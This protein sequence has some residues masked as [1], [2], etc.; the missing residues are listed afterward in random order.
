M[1]LRLANGI[2]PTDADE[3][4]AFV[5]A[6]SVLIYT[7]PGISHLVPAVMTSRA[8]VQRTALLLGLLLWSVAGAVTAQPTA[9]IDVQNV[10]LDRALERAAAAAEISLVYEADL[11]RN[12]HTSCSVHETSPEVLLRCL[13]DDQPVDFVQASSGTY[14]LRAAAGQPP[15]HG[16]L[17]GVVR[18][19]KHG[20]PLAK[21][22]V[23]LPESQA[24]VGVATDTTGRF[25]VSGLLPGPHTVVVSHLGYERYEAT[26]FVPSDST[27]RY[28]VGLSP[29]LLPTDSV[30]ID[31]TEHA[32][33]GSHESDLSAEE[34]QAV[35]VV[36]ASDVFEAASSLM[37]VTAPPPYADLH[38]QGGDT[39]GH[40]LRLDGV[41]VRDPVSTG[42]L[43][44]AFSPLALEGLTARKAGFG[45]LHGS[46]LSG[47]LE[48]EHALS[49]QD[50]QY[51]TVRI[52]PLSVNA[53]VQGTSSLGAT[54]MT[55]MAATRV[56]IWDVYQDAAL[57]DLIDRWSTLDP[58][59]AS[60]QMDTSLVGGALGAR[61]EPTARFYDVHGAAQFEFGPARRLHVSAYR[62]GSRIGADLV[63][64]SPVSTREVSSSLFA[65]SS[66]MEVP[67]YDQYAWTNT[68]AQARYETPV[69]ARTT[70]TLKASV[71]HYRGRSRSEMGPL[72][73]SDSM[74]GSLAAALARQ[75]AQQRGGTNEISE[76]NLSGRLDFALA[77][78]S[79][80]VLSAEATHLSSGFEMGNAFVPRLQHR[81]RAL[82]FTTSAEASLGVGPHTLFEGGLRLTALSSRKSL[83]AEPRGRIQYDRTFDRLGTVA[84]RLGGGLYR[85]YTSEFELSRDGATA[86]VP[87]TQVWLPIEGVLEPSRTYHLAATSSW[88]PTQ[89]WQITLEAYRKWQPHLLAVHYPAL[90][91]RAEGDGPADLS[92]FLTSSHGAAVGGGLRV[93]HE[94]AWLTTSLRY[95]YS[96][97]RR[98]FPGRFDGRL[99]P[100]PWSEPHRLALDTEVP[101]GGGVALELRGKGIWGRPWGYRR[102]YYA[103]LTEADLGTDWRTADLDRPGTHVLSPLYRFDA[104]LSIARSWGGVDVEG[105]IGVLNVL[106]RANAADWVLQPRPTGGTMRGVRTLP[107]RRFALTLQVG[108]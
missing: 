58:M 71:S 16:Q 1:H 51:G 28:A 64:G 34:L 21:A 55:A 84:L 76:V 43:L 73:R 36:G 14:V 66:S 54:P 78:R 87:S 2:G 11:V 10:P 39:G 27:A 93:Q 62:G 32:P 94:G 41:P 42:R 48:L 101:F 100:V 98:T 4:E 88:A 33:S 89:A 37:G 17:T 106:D 60:A 44:G 20:R 30:V 108:Y 63:L 47:T 31:A 15:Q 97:T 22:H 65:G 104:G 23:Q 86:V 95:A 5:R 99:V 38:I 83:Y 13:L 26:V 24:Q 6:K 18:D 35:G 12:H 67:T 25:H 53:Q 82:H 77:A 75:G 46:A 90:R 74:D 81:S 50:A 107:G 7:R 68:V 61:A 105:Q 56:G 85:T 19:A 96:R 49:G 92:R 45:V 52:D 80:L 103:Y 91:A 70:G 57:H 59:L 79:G 69:A 40:T 3:N 29:T 9:S 8:S 102:A 72:R